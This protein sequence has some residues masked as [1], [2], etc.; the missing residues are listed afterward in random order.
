MND[1]NKRIYIY[2]AG[3]Y[4]RKLGNELQELGFDI[5]A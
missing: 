2:G 1:V 3:K 4:G 5:E